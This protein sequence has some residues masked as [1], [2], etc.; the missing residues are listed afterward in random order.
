MSFCNL[1]RKLHNGYS[2]SCNSNNIDQN[3]KSLTISVISSGSFCVPFRND[4]LLFATRLGILFK[5]V[6]LIFSGLNLAT[7]HFN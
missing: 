2:M 4:E 3:S 6:T 5:C 7:R 1:L